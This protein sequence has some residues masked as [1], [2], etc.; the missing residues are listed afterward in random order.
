MPFQWGPS[1]PTPVYPPSALETN[2]M[3]QSM[4]SLPLWLPVAFVQW[5]AWHWWKQGEERRLAGHLCPGLICGVTQ[6]TSAFS[7]EG[8][9]SFAL[10]TACLQVLET[11]LPWPYS[12]LHQPKGEAQSCVAFFTPPTPLLIFPLSNTPQTTQF[13][14]AV[15]CWHPYW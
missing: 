10:Y 14:C 2:C 1:S 3:D 12:G 8:H 13:D 15:S 9:S 7:P 6:G 11:S 5:G 4:G